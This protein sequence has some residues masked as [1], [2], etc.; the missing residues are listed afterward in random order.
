[1]PISSAYYLGIQGYL[2]LFWLECSVMSSTL[3]SIRKTTETDFTTRTRHSRYRAI[4]AMSLAAMLFSIMGVSAK[5]AARSIPNLPTLPGAEIAFFRYLSGVIALLILSSMTGKELLGN[6]RPGLFWRGLS[7]G[8]ASTCFFLGIQYT[9]LTHATLL[10]NTFIIWASLFAVFWLG[11]KLGWLGSF[12]VI[13]ASIGVALVTNPQGGEIR[14]G[15]WIS[16]FSGIMAGM[17]VVQIRRLRQT[18][19]S[20]SIFFYF[21][22]VGLPISLL[23]MLLSHSKFILPAFSQVPILLL[24]GVSSVCSQLLMTYGYKEMR[25]AQG[26]LI[27]LTTVLSS[28][29]LSHWIFHDPISFYTICGGI[30]IIISAAVLSLR[31][32]KSVIIDAV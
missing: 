16:L 1:M 27:M 5:W 15:D 11:E 10:N 17:A 26:S 19:N 24:V 21:N 25:A 12:A 8:L 9:S 14:I 29:L 23:A 13:G 3:E 30:L 7:G 6:D 4:A 2:A 28:A 31:S 32:T 20:F 22:M 18:E